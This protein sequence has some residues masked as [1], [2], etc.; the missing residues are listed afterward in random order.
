VR[1]Y[2]VTLKDGSSKTITSRDD[3]RSA[4]GLWSWSVGQ[5]T[6][7]VIHFNEIS[8]LSSEI[9]SMSEIQIDPETGEK[10]N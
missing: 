6:D 1:A 4:I 7:Q 9:T 10:V 2:V 8:I 5:S 3:T